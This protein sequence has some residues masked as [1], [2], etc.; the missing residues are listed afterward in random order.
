V[1]S[2]R[3]DGEARPERLFAALVPPARL[4]AELHAQARARLAPL[5]TRLRIPDAPSLH[6]TLRFFG[7]VDPGCAGALEGELARRLRAARAPELVIGAAGSFGGDRPRV[8]WL[9]LDDRTEPRLLDLA[10]RAERAA[11]AVG[12]EP[13]ARAF[14]P[15]LTLARV[16]PARSGRPGHLALPD[17]FAG[18]R[19]DVA[20]R[21]DQV[22][23]FR[24][25]GGGRYEERASFALE[26]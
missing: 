8:L 4:Q 15:H 2:R 11:I 19:P 13:E 10:A 20:W 12:L 16:R 7:D 14:R 24:T 23:L 26:R 9:A 5:V 3:S 6:V 22:L 25:A 21:P 1:T 17:G 18:W